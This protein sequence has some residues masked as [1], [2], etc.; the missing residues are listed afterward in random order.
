MKRTEKEFVC[1]M[2]NEHFLSVAHHAQYC[3][4][5]R[6]IRQ[7]QRIKEHQENARKGNAVMIG[8][9]RNCATCGKPFRINSAAQLYC[10][11]ECK[12]KRTSSSAAVCESRRKNS[13]TF[14]FYLPKGSRVH[15]SEAAEQLGMTLSDLLRCA[16]YNY[17]EKEYPQAIANIE[18]M[19]ATDS[20]KE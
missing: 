16:L 18:N 8:S 3:E 7:K 4:N 14:T 20:Q 13:D 11:D 5:C 19:D 6:K 10:S 12:P 17:L 9:T 2:C 1:A 15:L